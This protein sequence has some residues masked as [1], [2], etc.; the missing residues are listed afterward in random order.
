MLTQAETKS[1]V[2]APSPNG[3]N[4]RDGQGRFA[5]GNPGG[6]GNPHAQQVGKLR[7]ALLRAVSEADMQAIVARLV[8]L[9]KEGNVQA[10]K[11]VIDRCI[12][13]PVE[14]DLIERI[15]DL[16]TVMEERRQ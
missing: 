7:S 5:R 8:E 6:P 12:G 9:A 13:R 3:A 14:A 15:E 10:A 4:G 2:D 1:K 11:E 16:E